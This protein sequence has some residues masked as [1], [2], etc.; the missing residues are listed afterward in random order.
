MNMKKQ[1]IRMIS[2]FFII[3]LLFVLT[4][5]A[6]LTVTEYKPATKEDVKISKQK[7]ETYETLKKGSKLKILT[8]NTGYGALGD[9]ADF[10]MDGGK[11]VSTATQARVQENLQGIIDEL[12][13]EK[14]DILF[15]QEVD[16]DSTRSHHINEC[17][18]I[19]EAM[20]GYQ[21]SFANNF[22]VA[23]I[24]YP[25]PPI[26][27]VDSGILTL[28]RFQQTKSTRISLP[29]PFS[30]PVRLG[31]LKR[32]L[33]VNRIPIEDSDKELV[34]I[35]LHL[36]AYDDG[37]GKAA[38]TKKLLKIMETERRKGNYV[39]A[40][41]DFNQTFSNVDSSAYKPSEDWT[42]GKLDTT[43]F[44]DGWNFCMDNETPTCRA[45]D[46][47]YKGSD[48]NDFSYFMLD[49][50]IVSDNVKVSSVKTVNKNFK[51]T[52]HNPVLLNV[53]LE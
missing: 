38:Q 2:T 24:P 51:N 10:F 9:N 49:G 27:K 16:Q 52:D 26:G 35:N 48:S 5:F 53:T 47:V 44:G 40:G 43:E 1:I 28:S 30:W 41:G 37:E 18:D 29:C 25:W 46:K 19:T 14:A 22:K 33:L 42:P 17:Q 4:L 20:D 21:S 8:W 15:L 23:Y 50:F 12:K 34:L 13:S 7:T 45:L 36:E 39:I 6:I 32:C 31:N 11:S 3:L